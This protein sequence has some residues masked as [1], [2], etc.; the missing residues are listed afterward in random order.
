MKARTIRIIE[1]TLTEEESEAMQREIHSATRDMNLPTLLKFQAVH[2]KAV[3]DGEADS[4]L[5]RE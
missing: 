3:R 1:I 2:D 4:D 5:M